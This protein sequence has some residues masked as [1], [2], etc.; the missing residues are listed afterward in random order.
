[1]M[2]AQYIHFVLTKGDSVAVGTNFLSMGHLPLVIKKMKEEF[3]EVSDIERFPGVPD[4]FAL[5][6]FNSVDKLKLNLSEEV[7]Q[8]MEDISQLFVE[9][10]LKTV[11]F[12]FHFELSC[13][14]LS[15]D[16]K[17]M[18]YMDFQISTT[19]IFSV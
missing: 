12:V 18:T 11:S 16:D 4:M 2:P 19:Y 9:D 17:L 3:F 14:W 1:M 13:F 6:L 10:N 5:F 7:K 15:T 8:L